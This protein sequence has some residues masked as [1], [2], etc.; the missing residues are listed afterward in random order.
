MFS[1]LTKDEKLL[2]LKCLGRRSRANSGGVHTTK[3]RR[4]S[5]AN[6][7]LGT[8]PKRHWPV[9]TAATANVSLSSVLEG[10]GGAWLLRSAQKGLARCAVGEV[11]PV[12]ASRDAAQPPRCR[13]S[14]L[15]LP[16]QPQE[17]TAGPHLEPSAPQLMMLSVLGSSTRSYLGPGKS[18][19]SAIASAE[20]RDRTSQ[21]RLGPS[22]LEQ[23]WRRLISCVHQGVSGALAAL[24]RAGAVAE[25]PPLLSG[26]CCTTGR[27]LLR[28]CGAIAS[29]RRHGWGSSP[30]GHSPP[31]S[32]PAASQPKPLEP[33]S[34][35]SCFELGITRVKGSLWR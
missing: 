10:P 19:A 30:T 5:R 17:L 12:V 33:R 32:A 16:H 23:E 8:H 11:S 7:K 1:C 15:N 2:C 26:L 34:R 6:S 20:S 3:L 18:A 14:P 13:Y 29:G 9:P 4:T 31:H 27:S 24:G 22:R 25:P 35:R 28:N 21:C